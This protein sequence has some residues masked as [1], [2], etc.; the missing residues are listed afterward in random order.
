MSAGKQV[1]PLACDLNAISADERTGHEVTSG[2]ILAAVTEVHELP[3]GYAFRLP[4]DSALLKQIAAFIANERLCCPFFRFEL[5]V[6]PGG[7]P[8]WLKLTGQE[9][10]KEFVAAEMVSHIN[11]P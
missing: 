1:I 11:Q 7:E 3:D 4:A 5:V 10:V 8:F 2:Q 6:E 9:G